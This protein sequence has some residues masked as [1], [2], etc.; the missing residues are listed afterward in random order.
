VGEEQFDYLLQHEH[1]LDLDTDAIRKLAAEQIDQAEDMLVECAAGVSGMKDWREALA[2]GQETPVADK[3]IEHWKEI[4]GEVAGRVRKAGIATLPSGG[5]LE[6][7]PTPEF[8]TSILPVAGYIEPPHFESEA[9]AYFCVTIPGADD[10]ERLLPAHARVNAMA[11]VIR[12][13]YPGRHTFLLQRRR[14]CGERL[15]YLSRGNVLEAGWEAYVLGAVA[16]S[17][18]FDDEPLLKLHAHHDNLLSAL[19]VLVDLELHT[20][21]MTEERAVNELAGK[22]GIGE[23]HAWQI[24]S[25]LAAAPASSVGPLAGRLMIE[26]WR[27]KYS[28][29][30][31]REFKLKDFH[32]KLIRSSA[33][34]PG[35]LEKR[36]NAALKREKR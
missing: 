35:M 10:V 3:L 5:S 12:Q 30:L 9:V 8:E 16:G 19:R 11:R 32:D 7:A 27:E 26:K 21:R 15:A 31:G 36:L 25:N 33:L 23:K 22:G 6:V 2:M 14:N 18:E 17:G 1:Q 34:P 24:V 28:K 4:I 13:I 20:G 29:A